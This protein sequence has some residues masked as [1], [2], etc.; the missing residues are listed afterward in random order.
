LRK[1]Q[2]PPDYIRQI[3]LVKSDKQIDNLEVKVMKKWVV[4]FC[5]MAA[6]FCGVAPVPGQD[7][8]RISITTT[9]DNSGV[10]KVLLPPFEEKTRCKV[11]VIA[12][13]TAKALK[14]GEYGDVDVV[15]VHA[16]K[17]EDKFVA[18]GFGV[19][20][21]DVMYNDYVIVGPKDDP[22]KIK[23]IKTAAE[24]LK[25]IADAKAVFVSRADSSG[26]HKAEQGLWKT[27]GIK[28]EG[29]WYIESGLDMGKTLAIATDKKGYTLVDRGTFLEHEATTGLVILLQGDEALLNPY[30]VIAVNPK[31][32]SGVNYELAK[33]FID[34]LTGPEG[35]KAIADFKP[36]G[37]QVYFPSAGKK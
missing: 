14:L 36:N 9:T 19:D 2:G 25:R 32:H 22:A 3:R 35:Q 5:V 20:R 29:Q 37:K 24:A 16:R 15:L 10:M 8:L 12:V 1:S 33:K 23:E 26:T 18:D 13:G 34:Y 27:T 6:I 31:K 28:P 21:R 17:D 11:D 30:G 7:T 4:F